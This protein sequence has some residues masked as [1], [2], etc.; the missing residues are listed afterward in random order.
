MVKR[1]SAVV[2]ALA[3]AAVLAACA[4]LFQSD[5]VLTTT[6]MGPLVRLTWGSATGDPGRTVAWYRI[7][8]DGAPAALVSGSWNSCVL[9]GLSP[10]TTYT[11]SI[12]ATDDQGAWSGNYGGDLAASG[13]LSV[14][15]TTPAA[16]WAGPSRSCVST[17]DTDGDGLP[18]AVETNSGTYVSAA[19]TGTNPNLADTDGDRLN[20]GVETATGQYVSTGNTG[21]NPNL[22]DTDGDALRDGDEVLGTTAG[23][24]LPALGTKPVHKD[25]L[26]E[27]D[28]FADNLDS[29]T[30]GAHNHRPTQAVIDRMTAAYAAGPVTNP[31]GV[32]GVNVIS[33]F[34]QGGGFGGGN[35]IADADGVLSSGVNSGE[36]VGIKTANFAANRNGYFHYVLMVHRYNTN[37]GSSGQAEING[38]DLIVSLQCSYANTVAVGNTI[39]HEAGHNLGL[40]HGGNVD[41]PNYKPNYD[42]IM[43]YRY[44]FPGVDRNCVLGGDGVL[45]YSTGSM[46]SLNEASLRETDGICN[47]VDIDW[48]GNG[49]IDA[50]PVWVDL[51]SDGGFTTISDWNDW[52]H[53]TFAGVGDGD[54]APFAEP[55]VVTEQPTPANLPSGG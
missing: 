10:S 50:S 31:D 41:V 54:G 37:S 24:N 27:F 28:W 34:G 35:L 47:G 40:R 49:S 23:L 15:Y 22:A 26:F 30:C 39:M 53:I 1:M 18:N 25:L 36:Y 52:S 19:A 21:T 42:S 12:T 5:D 29:G 7:D 16:G 20:D 38:D 45:D 8:V 51:T 17:T 46:A 14:G 32:N 11:I 3:V 9:T 55:E 13:R 33:D 44:Q 6:P 43:N 4:P 2:A 48:D